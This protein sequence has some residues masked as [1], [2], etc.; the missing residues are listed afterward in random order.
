MNYDVWRRAFSSLPFLALAT[1]AGQS[2]R[3]VS[4]PHQ[5]SD[6]SVTVCLAFWSFNQLRVGNPLA[7]CRDKQRIDPIAFLC[8]S[9]IVA[10]REFIKVAVDVLRADPVADAKH[11][12]LEM[13]PCAF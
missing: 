7:I 5:S 4:E 6:L 3:S 12:P 9:A 2:E 1:H 8:L 11:L 10:Q 13:R